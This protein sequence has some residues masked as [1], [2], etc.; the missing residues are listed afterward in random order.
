MV[1]ANE[2]GKRS[3]AKPGPSSGEEQIKMLIDVA[4]YANVLM[5]FVVGRWYQFVHSGF[6]RD[7]LANWEKQRLMLLPDELFKHR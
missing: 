5:C 1:V 4:A 7:P 3:S 6:E 2:A